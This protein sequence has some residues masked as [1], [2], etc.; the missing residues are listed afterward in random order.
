[1]VV[2]SSHRRIAATDN[3]LQGVKRD[4]TRTMVPF[5]LVDS[6]Q[7]C[8]QSRTLPL[9]RIGQVVPTRLGNCKGIERTG[10][11][12]GKGYTGW[13]DCAGVV[14]HKSP[15]RRRLGGRVGAALA[16]AGV[17]CGWDMV[18]GVCTASGMSFVDRGQS[19]APVV[20]IE[21]ADF[22]GREDSWRS[23]IHGG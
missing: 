5:P 4:E 21:R 13:G 17:H 2:V 6:A 11:G 3:C 12:T 8:C 20:G 22:E 10:A 14:D 7:R 1:M 16:G 19:I 9:T 18:D 23:G 15:V